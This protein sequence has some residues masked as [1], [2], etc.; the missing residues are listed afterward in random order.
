[1]LLVFIM[2]DLN[3]LMPFILFYITIWFCFLLGEFGLTDKPQTLSLMR[4][5]VVGVYLSSCIQ[6]L[7]VNFE[8]IIYP[9]L[10]SPFRNYCS[11]STFVFIQK[12]VWLIPIWE[13][14]VTLLLLFRK[15]RKVGLVMAIIIHIVIL[16][17]YSPLHLNYF[18]PLFPFNVSLIFIVFYLFRNYEGNLFSDLLLV[19]IKPIVI[20]VFIFSI[21]F[22]I[23]YYFGYGH[24]YLSYD[25]YSGN[26]RYTS[27]YFDEDYYGNL[28][29]AYKVNA[30]KIEGKNIYVICLDSW[31]YYETYGTIYRSEG[32][33]NYYKKIFSTLKSSKSHLVFMTYKNGKKKFEFI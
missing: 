14:I 22:P 18:G 29:T 21:G 33:F 27:L 13:G 20:A 3:F 16:I 7:N 26:Y 8:H 19:M 23:S 15:T 9:W 2:S 4:L 28:P 25:L 11:Y 5:L 1:M 12:L 10:I 6:K 32:S 30:R 24:A 17:L 31:L